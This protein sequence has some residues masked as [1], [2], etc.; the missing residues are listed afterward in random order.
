MDMSGRL[1]FLTRF[2]RPQAPPADFVTLEQVAAFVSTIPD[3]NCVI[4][5]KQHNRIWCT[6]DVRDFDS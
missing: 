6:S 3:L 2:I 4:A 5:T 1:I